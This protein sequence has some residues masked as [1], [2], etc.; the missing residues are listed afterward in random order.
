MDI[1]FNAET[2]EEDA[3]H[4]EKSFCTMPKSDNDNTVVETI[5]LGSIDACKIPAMPE[6]EL[7]TESDVHAFGV[8][9][10][11][12]QLEEAGFTILDRQYDQAYEP[13]A[14]EPVPINAAFLVSH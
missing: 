2:A 13:K 5:L 6:P 12:K 3:K 10:V 7:M 9:I 14:Q 8:E 11:F 4:A 1:G